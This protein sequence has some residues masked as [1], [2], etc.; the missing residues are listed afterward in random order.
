MSNES[1][2]SQITQSAGTNPVR[3]QLGDLQMK[4]FDI[5]NNNRKSI[6]TK[7]L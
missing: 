4:D 6:I 7:A 2:T 1:I 5:D 3:L